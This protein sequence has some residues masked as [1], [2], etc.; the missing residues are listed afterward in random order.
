[1]SRDIRSLD[2]NLLKALDALLEE[3]SV[4]RAAARLGLTQPAVS[5]MLT[6]LREAFGDPLFIRTQRGIVPTPRAQ[7]LAV[8]LRQAL[9]GIETLLRPEAFD[10]ARA[11][12]TLGIAAT[13]Y[14][15][16]AILVPFVAA[17]RIRA[18]GLRVAVLPVQAARLP[19]Q[20]ER[21]ELHLA[22]V[23]PDSLP[24]GLR[25]RR[26]FEERYVCALRAGHPAAA[27][28][29]DLDRFCALDHALVSLSGGG[30]E[31]AT[32]A[33]L[34]RLGRARRVALSVTS[35]LALVEILRESD[36]VA[37]LPARLAAGQAGLAL[38]PP[39]LEVPGFTKLAAWHERTQRDPGHRWVRALLA[40]VCAGLG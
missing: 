25:V 6:R 11:D 14:A 9:S 1:M 28:P 2:L 30:F 4:T 17:L 31:G 18:P 22:L 15:L 36:L 19:E 26:L 40:E 24:P 13:D 37:L 33:A 16:R 5:G 32:D 10:P 34:A 3:R 29:L 8:P 20:L 27:A 7:A 39:P 38:R 21:G 12:F 35:F 23:T